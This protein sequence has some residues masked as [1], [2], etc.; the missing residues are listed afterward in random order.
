MINESRKEQMFIAIHTA[1][2]L[3]R[4]TCK[5]KYNRIYSEPRSN[6]YRVKIYQSNFFNL[7]TKRKMRFF[8]ILKTVLRQSGFDYIIN[9]DTPLKGLADLKIGIYDRK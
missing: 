7:S 1:T 6:H 2:E 9:I 3:F 8:T 4:E 5:L